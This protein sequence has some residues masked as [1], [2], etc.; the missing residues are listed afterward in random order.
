MLK[1]VTLLL[2]LP[3]RVLCMQQ[4]R[5]PVTD[6]QEKRWHEVTEVLATIC[7]YSEVVGTKLDRAS[8]RCQNI[9]D[10]LADMRRSKK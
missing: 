3:L 2:L 10:L 9:L 4:E 1:K 6:S 8:A 7:V 5:L